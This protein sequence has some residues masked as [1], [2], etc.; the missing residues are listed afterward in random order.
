MQKITRNVRDL[1]SEERRL[2]EAVLGENLR[3]NQLVVIQVLDLG[4]APLA[5][6][7]PSSEQPTGKLPE[8]CNVYDGL[9][10]KD[11]AEVEGVAL[12]RADLSRPS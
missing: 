10:D 8:W 3:E 4:E 1:K 9:S 2:Y 6:K 11:I 5:S 12:Q 7:E